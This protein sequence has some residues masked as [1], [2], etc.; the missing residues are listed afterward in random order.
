[1]FDKED[2]IAMCV[3]ADLWT[4]TRTGAS[5]PVQESDC[6]TR[7]PVPWNWIHYNRAIVMQ[8]SN[9]MLQINFFPDHSKIILCPLMGAITLI[10]MM[11]FGHTS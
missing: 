8:L 3:P 4:L 6:L 1:M 2:E 5:M 11:L 9:G 7:L 10:G